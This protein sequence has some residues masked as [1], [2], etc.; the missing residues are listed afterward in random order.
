MVLENGLIAPNQ[1]FFPKYTNG[2]YPFGDTTLIV[3][4]GLAHESTRIPRLFNRPELVM[5]TL[6]G[7]PE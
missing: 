1:G 2:A 7:M 4:R 5:I 3:S 6:T